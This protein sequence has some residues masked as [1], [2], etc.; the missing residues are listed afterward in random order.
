MIG[1]HQFPDLE[2]GDRYAC[3]TVTLVD[4]VLRAAEVETDHVADTRA[5]ARADHNV[6][7]V[8]DSGTGGID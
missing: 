5:R 2:A 7:Y 3:G 1:F 8:E 6:R 4:E